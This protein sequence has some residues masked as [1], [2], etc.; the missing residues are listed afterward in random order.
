MQLNLFTLNFDMNSIFV[1]VYLYFI[2]LSLL[3]VVVFNYVIDP[4]GIHQAFIIDGVN[5]YKPERYANTPQSKLIN[6]LEIKP[7]ILLLGT[8]RTEF[9]IDPDIVN[10]PLG[11]KPVYNMALGLSNFT[12]MNYIADKLIKVNPPSKVIIG[13]DFISFS[14]IKNNNKLRFNV[15]NESNLKFA[16]SLLSFGSL[17]ASIETVLS[18]NEFSHTNYKYNG[19][20]TSRSYEMSLLEQSHR[21]LFD[22]MNSKYNYEGVLSNGFNSNIIKSNFKMLIKLLEKLHENNIGTMVFFTPIHSEL[23]K[24]IYIENAW[25]SFSDIKRNLAYKLDD[26]LDSVQLW[27]FSSINVMSTELVPDKIGQGMKWYYDSAHYKPV[28]GQLIMNDILKN[29]EKFGKH[30]TIDNVD[31]ILKLETEKMVKFVAGK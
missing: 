6:M 10:W 18:Q 4:Y 29:K 1:K 26:D 3:T 21:D 16:W 7:N 11:S 27:D 25:E 15:E 8:S 19:V 20:R 14:S 22:R 30:L 5:K 31:V 28:L 13:V 9:G 2:T 12:E 24:K 17:K 23:L